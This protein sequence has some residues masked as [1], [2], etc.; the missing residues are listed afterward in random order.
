MYRINNQLSESESKYKINL[1]DPVERR[2]R[3]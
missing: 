1:S 3:Y 2:Q